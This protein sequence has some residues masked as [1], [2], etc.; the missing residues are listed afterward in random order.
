MIRYALRCGEAHSFE[1]WFSDSASFEVQKKRG[2]VSCPVCG[3]LSIEK[4]I[5]AP[6]VVTSERKAAPKVIDESGAPAAPLAA[7]PVPAVM[8]AGD[9]ELRDKIRALRSLLQANT[10]DVGR[11]FAEEAR[12]M[13]Y[14]E[15]EQRAIR[16]EASRDD[17]QDLLEEGVP[18]LPLPILPDEKH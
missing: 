4:E 7:P 13:H 8:E 16:G 3:N 12:K 1:S 14:G 2:L 5:M 15:V 10:A 18:I 11:N 9:K 17:V 6:R